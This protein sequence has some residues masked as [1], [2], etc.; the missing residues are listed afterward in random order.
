MSTAAKQETAWMGFMDIFPV[1]GTVK[2]SVELVLALYEGNDAVIKEKQKAAVNFVKESLK[3]R[4]KLTL[5]A[6]A[7]EEEAVAVA[8]FSGLSNVREVRKEMIIEH[9]LQGSKRGSKPL[10][11][12]EKKERLKKL[13][14]DMLKKIHIIDPDFY[15]ELKEEL[16]RSKR[17]EHVLNNDILKFHSKVLSKFIQDNGIANL[18]RYDQIQQE[19]NELGKHTLSQNTA[20]DIQTNMVFHFGEDEFYVNANAVMYG[21]YCRALRDA[22]LVVLGHI[23]PDDVTEEERQRV[24]FVIDN[25]N[26]YEIYV[27]D[28]AKV[29]WIANQADK[30]NKF[31]QVK[32]EVVNMYKTDRGDNW[33]IRI[34]RLVQPLFRH[35]QFQRQRN[36]MTSDT[37]WLGSIHNVPVIGK[38]KE[39]VEL[40]LALYEGNSVVIREKEQALKQIV[41][42]SRINIKYLKI[43][44]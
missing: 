19:V 30:Q 34:L 27:D 9:V 38:I 16:E 10:T 15:E 36:I 25:M 41:Q 29:R 35:P 28:F 18:Q 22:L 4:V 24:N 32:Q 43:D 11:P 17:G 14:E 13:Q 31:R 20:A 40:V 23:N 37:V 8:E 33:C 6:V 26:N 2:E 42:L 1:I 39:S 21:V 5:P 12:A 3:R 7:E 44:R